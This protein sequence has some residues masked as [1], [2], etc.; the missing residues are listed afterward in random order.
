MG[1]VYWN[2]IAH[3]QTVKMHQKL[4]WVSPHTQIGWMKLF[5]GFYRIQLTLVTWIFYSTNTPSLFILL[6]KVKSNCFKS[7]YK[8][9]YCNS[10]QVMHKMKIWKKKWKKKKTEVTLPCGTWGVV[11]IENGVDIACIRQVHLLKN[12]PPWNP[13]FDEFC[14]TT[15]DKN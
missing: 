7:Y 15:K 2:S 4:T 3:K 12:W 14:T 11:V 10:H 5:Y 6:Y 9:F 13:S 8:K 1:Y